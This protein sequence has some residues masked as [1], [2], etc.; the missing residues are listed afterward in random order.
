[1]RRNP[2]VQFTLSN[3][4]WLAGSLIL[5]LVIWIA[6]NM[7]D[8]PVVQEEMTNITVRVELP[9]GYVITDRPD[10]QTVTAV[11]RAPRRDWDLMVPGDILVTA[12][13]SERREAGEYRVELEAEVADPLHGRVVAI[14]PSTWALAI[15][16]A[17]QRILPINVVVTETPPLGYTFSRDFG[18][19]ASEVTVRGSESSVAQVARVEARLDLSDALNPV[20]KTVNLTPVQENGFRARDVELSPALVTCDI[21]VMVSEGVTPVE[22]LPDRAGTTPPRGYT[23]QGYSNIDPRRVGVTG[24]VEAIESL[25]SVVRTSPI[26]LSDKTETF[27]TEVP[28]V[29]P[30]GVALV[31]GDELV[32]VT[33]LITPVFDNR[34]FAEVPV[35][36]IG[37]D[38][39]QFAI[40]GLTNTV[41][42]N[43]SG[44]QARLPELDVDDIRVVVDLSGLEPGNHQLEPQA[45]IIGQTEEAEFSVRSVLPEQLSVTIEALDMRTETATRTP[46]AAPQTDTPPE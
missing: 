16:P 23:F 7:A 4:G 3:L 46:T 39:T 27:T 21:D 15:A 5:A 1:M 17:Q 42:V 26:D 18:C 25:N 8:N 28:L 30:E 19:D 40:S 13:L 45:T 44:P 10:T 6:A 9:D 12:D 14:R 22:V 2:F 35:E 29:L 41:T 37:L 34:E 31:E 24:P 32:R 20:K 11:V 36:V 43:V 33:V 38:T